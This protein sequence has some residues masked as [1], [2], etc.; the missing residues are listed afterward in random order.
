MKKTAHHF[1][2]VLRCFEHAKIFIDFSSAKRKISSHSSSAKSESLNRLFI[3]KTESPNRLFIGKTEKHIYWASPLFT[4]T[5]S[6]P[7]KLSGQLGHPH[8]FI[9]IP[10][11]G[12]LAFPEPVLSLPSLNLLANPSVPAVSQK[13][14]LFSVPSIDPLE[15]L[16]NSVLTME[17]A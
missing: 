13:L 16:V 3:G 4:L 5:L 6:G 10:R 12:F 17:I 8:A 2:N 1:G 7:M 15:Y 11:P 14:C 9:P